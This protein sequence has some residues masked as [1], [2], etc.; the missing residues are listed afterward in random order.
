MG[1]CLL[2]KNGVTV[3]STAVTATESDVLIGKTYMKSN[4]DKG[5]GTKPDNGSPQ[6]TL[7]LN[8][9]IVLPSGYY[10][11]GTVKSSVP[12]Y[13]G[14]TIVTG[15]NSITVKTSGKYATGN[16]ELK[17]IANLTSAV[18]KKGMY[19]AGIGPGT[20]EGYLNEDPNMPFYYGTL[21]P[22]FTTDL[23]KITSGKYTL[24]SAKIIKDA[25]WIFTG[26]FYEGIAIGFA[27][28]LDFTKLSKVK[29]IAD[30]IQGKGLSLLITE[31]YFTD[32]L[33]N[34]M[35]NDWLTSLGAIVDVRIMTADGQTEWVLNLDN[36]TSDQRS[37]MKYIYV[38]L[39]IQS[40][41]ECE[42]NIYKIQ[43]V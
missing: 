29:I 40:S 34:A 6:K 2:Q 7:P 28:A 14:E 13:N 3:D 16:I 21:G 9:S 8:G 42:Y 43:C 18:I 24:G 38:F 30:K 10:G 11:G 35:G 20:W 33:A 41:A 32:Q 31:N 27:K 19:V 12:T 22:G 25:Y 1:E 17:P 37:K 39:G 36:Y 15:K 26:G 23:V 5:V 4:G